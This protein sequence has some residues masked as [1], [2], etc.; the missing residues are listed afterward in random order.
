MTTASTRVISPA[1][2][3]VR[4]MIGYHVK[5]V[6]RR[7][8]RAVLRCSRCRTSAPVLV[9]HSRS[10]G[11]P[12]ARCAFQRAGGINGGTVLDGQQ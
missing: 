3:W 11:Q 7:Q 1:T 12:L 6:D 2:P 9:E 10:Q 5:A 8:N 4:R